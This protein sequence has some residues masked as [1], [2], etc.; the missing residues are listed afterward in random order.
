MKDGDGGIN[1]LKFHGLGNFV[2]EEG[3]DGDAC[4]HG[5]VDHKG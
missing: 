4:M 5:A 1:F 3:R 2:L